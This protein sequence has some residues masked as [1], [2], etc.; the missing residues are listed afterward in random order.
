MSPEQEKTHNRGASLISKDK[1]IFF[2]FTYH[3][4]FFSVTWERDESYVIWLVYI[5][6]GYFT[7]YLLGGLYREFRVLYVVQ[8]CTVHEKLS[9]V[10]N[11]L[12]S[13]RVPVASCHW[14]TDFI[15]A[16]Y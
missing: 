11:Q 13:L 16:T 4:A 7:C 5:S 12:Q 8:E 1:V 9:A 3:L 2:L 10:W 6:F 14:G 15:I